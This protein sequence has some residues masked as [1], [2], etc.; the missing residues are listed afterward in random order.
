MKIYDVRI[1]HDDLEYSNAI[2]L[3][4]NAA[5]KCIYKLY[6]LSSNTF[7]STKDGFSFWHNSTKKHFTRYYIKETYVIEE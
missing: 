1:I 7:E 6:M 5:E 4:K 2:F 3:T